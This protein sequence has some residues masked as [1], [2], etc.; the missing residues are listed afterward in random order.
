ML[1]DSA[2]HHL[3]PVIRMI[4]VKII[5]LLILL[6]LILAFNGCTSASKSTTNLNHQVTTTAKNLSTMVTTTITEISN[7]VTFYGFVP[8]GTYVNDYIVYSKGN[9]NP[10]SLF[11]SG[12]PDVPQG[13]KVGYYVP[14]PL[15][16]GFWVTGYNPGEFVGNPPMGAEIDANEPGGGAEVVGY[17]PIIQ[18]DAVIRTGDTSIPITLSIKD[19]QNEAW[20]SKYEYIITGTYIG[21]SLD[22]DMTSDFNMKDP[23]SDATVDVFFLDT[24]APKYMHEGDSVTVC[25]FM[26]GVNCSITSTGS[27]LVPGF[28]SLYGTDNT[29]GYKWGTP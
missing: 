4:K 3:S 25:G 26:D 5:R 23:D 15:P 7:L 17:V 11:N 27:I 8:T 9:Y 29:N 28:G 14:G 16:D 19:L 21:G 18:I 24:L 22:P 1:Y 20:H 6:C 12:P 10:N 13:I 2:R